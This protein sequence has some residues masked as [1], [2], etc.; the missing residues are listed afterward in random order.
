MSISCVYIA[1]TIW[2][3][4]NTCCILSNSASQILWLQAFYSLKNKMH[5]EGHLFPSNHITRKWDI[6]GFITVSSSEHHQVHICQIPCKICTQ[7]SAILENSFR[8]KFSKSL[9]HN[10]CY[11]LIQMA[12][13]LY[14]IIIL[15]SQLTRKSAILCVS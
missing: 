10:M 2:R 1:S 4:E 8:Y 12:I 9:N 11:I 7:K 3:S 13:L 14:Y 5:R 15:S 6:Q